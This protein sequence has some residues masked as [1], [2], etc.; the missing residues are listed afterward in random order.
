MIPNK[1]QRR[2]QRERDIKL[3]AAAND[4][5]LMRATAFHESAHAVLSELLDYPVSHVTVVPRFKD[6]E[7]L[8]G[9]SKLVGD[10][11][12]NGGVP[13][14]G[15][16]RILSGVLIQYAGAFAE[17]R[18]ETLPVG[19]MPK[20]DLDEVRPKIAMLTKML[21]ASSLEIH[22]MVSEACNRMLDQTRIGESFNR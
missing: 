20:T 6:G 15:M 11:R 19:I 12:F 22:D 1:R 5:D 17:Y 13:E 9:E 16:L 7:L 21:G 10:A 8:Y 18:I 14:L 4:K 3:S 2:E